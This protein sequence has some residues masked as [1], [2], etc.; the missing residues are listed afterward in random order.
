MKT[1]GGRGLQFQQSEIRIAV[2][3]PVFALLGHVV[4]EYGCGFGVVSIEAVEYSVDV[5]WPFGGVVE[6]DTHFQ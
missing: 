3:G 2:I 4:L 1:K 6:G 5:F